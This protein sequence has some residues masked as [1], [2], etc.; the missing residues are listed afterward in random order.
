MCAEVRQGSDGIKQIAPYMASL[1]YS[2]RVIDELGDLL[3]SL[4]AVFPELIKY[5]RN[6]AAKAYHSTRGSVTK[7]SY[8]GRIMGTDGHDIDQLQALENIFE[9]E[10][11]SGGLSFSVFLPKDLIDRQRPGYVP[12]LLSGTYLLERDELQLSVNFRSQSLIE[13]GIFDLINVRRMQIEMVERLNKKRPRSVRSILPGR[14][15]IL[16]SRVFIHRRIMK[17]GN[18]KFLKR[19]E[20]LPQWIDTLKEFRLNRHGW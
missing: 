12:C 15:N 17:I 13:F 14:L 9:K 2:A 7:P 4:E 16:C 19:D 6:R 18:R 5:G 20:V 8:S 10:P 1:P 3:D 11:Y